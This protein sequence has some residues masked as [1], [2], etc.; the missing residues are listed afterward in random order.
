M[1]NLSYREIFEKCAIKYFNKMD[2]ENKNI[3][4]ENFKDMKL[5]V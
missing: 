5:I 4:R 2:G 1:E 3:F